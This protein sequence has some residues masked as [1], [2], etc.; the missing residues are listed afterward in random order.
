M[1]HIYQLCRRDGIK[2]ETLEIQSYIIKQEE[3]YQTLV[4]VFLISSLE[5]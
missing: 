2:P 4:T 1:A 5:H 3:Y